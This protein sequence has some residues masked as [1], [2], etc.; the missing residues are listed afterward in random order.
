MKLHEYEAKEIFKKYKIP[1]PEGFITS[2]EIEKLN[3]PV[4]IKAQVLVGGRGKAGGILFADTVDEANEK[5]KE[6]LNKDIKGEKVEKV[7]VEEK[8]PI[9]K[10]YYLGITID[11]AERK[12]VIMF[13]TEGGVEIEEVAKTN[14]EKIIKYHV[15]PQS[16]FL[17][18]IARN[19]LKDADIPSK[20][21]PK[22]ADIMY[23]LYNVFKD[24]DGML[25][26]INPVVITEDGR[27]LAADAV[28]NVDDDAYYRHDYTQFEEFSKKDKLEFAYVELDGDI[29]VI[30]NGAG[31]TLASM[32][33]VKEYGGNPACF[34]DIGG[35]ANEETVKKALEKVL[36]RDV[37]GI[38]INVL[39][40][41]TRCDEVAKGI[42][43]VLK[44]HPNVKFAVRMMG[45]NEEE[46]RKILTEN[47][48][49][50][51]RSME[52]AAKKLMEMIN[53]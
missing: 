34:L 4:V 51:E 52:G 19:I 33:M 40:G 46:G 23:K 21:I 29:G 36:E 3:K 9:E 1:V 13:S 15:N 11:R 18:Y 44:K 28:L 41:I 8:I 38:F 50:F 10:E 2:T 30:G 6:L 12:P 26:E 45:T 22:V 24:M 32:D 5:I 16:E 27:A 49:P 25:V 14:P 37:K 53:S 42:V 35:G 43:E 31:L 7:L 20:E 17:P 39:A 48:I 47:G